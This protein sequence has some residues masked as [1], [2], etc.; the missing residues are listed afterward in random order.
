MIYEP[1]GWQGPKPVHRGPLELPRA[2]EPELGQMDPGRVAD[3]VQGI[4]EA[5]DERLKGLAATGL[6]YAGVRAWSAWH[7]LREVP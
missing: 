1:Y 4:R 3:F 5:R 6:V 7:H 2:P